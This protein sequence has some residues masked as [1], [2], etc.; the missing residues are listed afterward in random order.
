MKYLKEHEADGITQRNQ[1][2]GIESPEIDTYIERKIRKMME[3]SIHEIMTSGSSFGKKKSQ[4]PT[5]RCV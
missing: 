1:R 5:S 3:F 4:I 2:N